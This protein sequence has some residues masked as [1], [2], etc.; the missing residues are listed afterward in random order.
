MKELQLWFAPAA[1]MPDSDIV[2][3]SGRSPAKD[4]ICIEAML[5]QE[6][7][8]IRD[9]HMQW[10]WQTG[11]I[12]AGS[13][14]LAGQLTCGAE[15]SMWWT[16]LIYERHPKLSPQLYDIYKLRCVEI[17]LARARPDA[18][19]LYGGDEQLAQ[20]LADLCAA[21]D[22]KFDQKAAPEAKKQ[23]QSLK[24][25]L[26]QAL[27]APMGALLRLAHWLVS[28][29]R[30]L[31]Y[32]P[33]LEPL[34]GN[35]P[36]AATIITYYPN[37][38]L[39]AAGEGRFRSRYWESLHDALNQEAQAERPQGP[40]F[41]RWLF[42][43]FPSPDLP[44]ARCIS[45]RDQFQ[46]KGLDGLS[47]KFLEEYISAGD[48]LAALWRW[49]RLASRSAKYEPV[50]RENCRTK[51]SRLDFWPYLK[52]QWR[53]S[54]AGWRCLERCLFE[55]AF[56]R[57]VKAAGPQRWNLFPLE[58]CP[59]ERMFTEKARAVAG[60]GQV[61]GV[62][63][64][65]IRP[66][67]FRYFDAPETFSDPDCATF[68]PDII[69]GNGSSACGQ[70]QANGMPQSRMR[71]VEALRYLYLAWAAADARAKLPAEAGEPVQPALGKKL[72]ILTSFFRDETEAH[73]ALVGEALEHG[74]LDDWAITL[75]PHPYLL[76]E[77]WLAGLAPALRERIFVSH[78]P[79]ATELKPQITVWASNSTTASV[80]AA[81][82]KL[83]LLVMG[84]CND[85]DLCP[86]QNAPGLART[87]TLEDVKSGLLANR[88]VDLPP[89]YFNLGTELAAWRK[90]LGLEPYGEPG[91][92][93]KGGWQ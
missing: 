84:P 37:I 63:H 72:L 35:G 6:L 17:L 46:K 49:A 83:P 70:W 9:E 42:I 73:L 69:A 76:P 23:E 80:E 48:V 4:C 2:L 14:T 89:D 93:A 22:I 40:H 1:D 81:L 28:I 33:D 78:A 52:D 57:Y 15:P 31:P 20:S 8:R 64:S 51:N 75:K 87:A 12:K 45:M 27:P 54:L 88:G 29:K 68:Q 92:A 3:W 38:D 44:L 55:R 60:N 58:N 18:L 50:F 39:H 16:S 43:R 82:R 90:L 41:V 24:L 25:R 19:C 56:R 59:W 32:K 66:T 7:L 47:F 67:D 5:A 71:Q 21:Y 65:A 77:T 13:G 61:I 62:Q 74:L 30:K 11:N 10:A 34:P 36:P 79:L 26:Y 91:H 53:Q 86:I 85:F